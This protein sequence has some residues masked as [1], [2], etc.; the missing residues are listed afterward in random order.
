[1][2][3]DKSIVSYVPDTA[4]LVERFGGDLTKSVSLAE[5]AWR[6]PFYGQDILGGGNWQLSSLADGF[7]QGLTL[8]K[9]DIKYF[10]PVYTARNIISQDV[11][12]TP[13]FHY[14]IE[15]KAK[16]KVANK[17]PNRVFRNP[18]HYQ[19]RSDFFLFLTDSL[20]TDGNAYAIA[21]RNDRGEVDSLYL[22]HPGHIWPYIIEGEIYYRFN[23]QGVREIAD[24]SDEDSWFPQRDVLHIRLFCPNHPLIGESPIKAA[25][26]S[27]STGILINSQMAKMFQ[28]LSRPSGILRHPGRLEDAAIT[29]IKKKFLEVTQGSDFGVPI[30]LK[31]GMD[32]TPLTMNAVDSEIIKSYELSERQV[33]Q[34]FRIPVHLSGSPEKMTS[35]SNFESL[36]RYYVQSCLSFYM[37]HIELAFVKFFKLEVNESIE[38]DIES[39]ILRTDLETRATAYSKFIQSGIAAPNELREREGLVPVK[40]GDEPRVQQQLV[41]LSWGHELAQQQNNPAPT[42]NESPAPSPEEPEPT[43]EDKAFAAYVAQKAIEKAMIA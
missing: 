1:M 29:R 22:V 36:F 2:E 14:L 13:I 43:E 15:N 23:D 24:L 39:A 16:I 33:F 30:V 34:L 19:T 9:N 41:P 31:E 38:F 8:N 28:N 5:G 3:G 42:N 26:L 4:Q 32:W 40:Y 37:T 27:A 35:L 18:N 6:G 12:R 11:A 7:Q 17:A 25:T 20:L 10:G 21:E